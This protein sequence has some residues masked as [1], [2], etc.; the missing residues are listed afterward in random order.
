MLLHDILS[1]GKTPP[2]DQEIQKKVAN[3]TFLPRKFLIR[4][5]CCIASGRRHDRS[6]EFFVFSPTFAYDLTIKR[7]T[8]YL[9]LLASAKHQ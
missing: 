1:L 2:G 7:K 5:C 8:S 3:N 4:T 9:L 6:G